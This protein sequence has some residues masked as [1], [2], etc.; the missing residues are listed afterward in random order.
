MV[1]SVER[2]EARESLVVQPPWVESVNSTYARP[3]EL[4]GFALAGRE[5]MSAGPVRKEA[6]AKPAKACR[7][8]EERLHV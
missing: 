5:S 8:E 2:R 1:L 4:S 7:T 6:C 3:Q